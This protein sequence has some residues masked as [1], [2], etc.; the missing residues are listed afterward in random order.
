MVVPAHWFF[1]LSIAKDRVRFLRLYATF[2]LGV[3]LLIGLS[4]HHPKY[5]SEP[6]KPSM[7]YRLHLKR[8][9]WSGKITQEQHDKYLHYQ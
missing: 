2:G 9:L 7:L 5:T 3:G 6:F 8:L 4:A 1:K